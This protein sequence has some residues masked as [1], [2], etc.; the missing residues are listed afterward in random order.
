MSASIQSRRQRTRKHKN[1]AVVQFGKLPRL[2]SLICTGILVKQGKVRYSWVTGVPLAWLTLV[3]TNLPPGELE[4]RLGKAAFSRATSNRRRTV[5]GLSHAALHLDVIAGDRET[6]LD[7]LAIEVRDP[8]P[9]HLAARDEIGGPDGERLDLPF[10]LQRLLRPWSHKSDRS[11]RNFGSLQNRLET[12][13]S[14]Q[15]QIPN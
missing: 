4:S 13:K 3:T 15:E 7:L 9:A 1:T 5:A 2:H 10:R 14:F 6:A 12:S 8:D 11:F